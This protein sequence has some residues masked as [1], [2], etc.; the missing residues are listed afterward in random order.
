MKSH[1]RRLKK[2][3]ILGETLAPQQVRLTRWVAQVIIK[4]SRPRVGPVHE[5][6]DSSQPLAFTFQLTQ[7]RETSLEP[8]AIVQRNVDG[9]EIR[10]AAYRNR[11]VAIH[12]QLHADALVQRLR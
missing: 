1:Q 6:V 10:T 8:T 2:S 12:V 3:G 5:R 7:L 9:V 11:F 4:S